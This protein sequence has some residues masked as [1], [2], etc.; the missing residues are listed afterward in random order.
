MA[1]YV[2]EKVKFT[3]YV[4]KAIEIATHN[5]LVSQGEYSKASWHWQHQCQD[6]EKSTNK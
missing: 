2:N 1:W 5:L 4:L 3:N 6:L